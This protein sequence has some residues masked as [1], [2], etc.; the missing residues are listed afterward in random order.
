[1]KLLRIIYFMIKPLRASCKRFKTFFWMCSAVIGMCLRSERMG[2][3]S[4]VRACALKSKAYGSLLNF[5]NG[6]GVD[7]EKLIAAWVK[8]VHKKFTPVLIGNKYR[9]YVADGL[10]NPKEGK[11][12]PGVK[13]L[14]NASENNSKPKHVMGHMCHMVSMLAS[15]GTATVAVPLAPRICGGI[16][17]SSTNNKK[18]N[19]KTLIDLF[20]KHFQDIVE[21]N[22]EE[23]SILIADAYYASGKVIK[24][25]IDHGGHLITRVKKNAV[26]FRLPEKPKEKQRGRPKTYGEKI[27]L[28]D[29]FND[30][31]S[32]SEIQMPVYDDDDKETVIKVKTM[33]L[34]WKPAGR[35]V[36]FVWAIH[37]KRGKIILMTTAMDLD[38]KDIIIAYGLR[39][40]IEVSFKSALH[41]VGTYGY[42]FWMKDMDPLKRHSKNQYLYF[43]PEQYRKQV[44]RKL[45][46]YHLHMMLGCIAQGCLQY[47]ALYHSKLVWSYFRSWL[48]TIRA[49]TIPS[50]QVVA[51]ALRPALLPFLHAIPQDHKMLKFIEKAADPARSLGCS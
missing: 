33:D 14:H 3:T 38:V 27:C 51:M 16:V 20:V 36:R 31:E 50:E 43:K 10:V 35:L 39:F 23:P 37:P 26:A 45:H 5:F 18:V 40:K 44:D 7:I 34:I 4:L 42:H 46:A 9:A 32:F 21:D 12:M 6:H 41:Q 25:M 11:K 15:S 8:V 30:E 49:N 1:M 19:K 17:S 13:S 29:V 48:R 28:R 24:G 2:V 47:L 22:P